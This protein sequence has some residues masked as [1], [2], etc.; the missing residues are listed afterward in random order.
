MDEMSQ[1]ESSP[2]LSNATDAQLSTARSNATVS[3]S[4]SWG[5]RWSDEFL[6]RHWPLLLFML[7]E[8]VIVGGLYIYH[9]MWIRVQKKRAKRSAVLRLTEEFSLDLLRHFLPSAKVE[10][11]RFRGM[12]KKKAVASVSFEDV[13][14]ELPSGEKILEG[15]SGEFKAGRMCAIMG[16]S[17]AGKTSLMNVLCGK[18]SYGKARGLVRFNGVEGDYEDYKTVMGFVPQDDIV[19]EGLTVGEQIRFSVDLRNP[20]SVPDSRRKLIYED[21]LNVM[22]LG[23]IQN[24][25]VGGLEKRGISGGQRKRVSIGLELAAD[26]TMLFLDEPTSGLDAASSLSI[27]HSLKKLAQLG[28]TSVMVVHQPR[29]SLFSL[30]DEVLLLGKGGRTVYLGPAL[31]AKGYFQKLGFVASDDENPADWIMDLIAGEIP[32]TRIPHFVPEMLYDLWEANRHLVQRA[33]FVKAQEQAME[34]DDWTSLVQKLDEDWRLISYMNAPSAMDP[35]RQGVLR[36]ADLLRLL[37]STRQASQE[38]EQDEMEDVRGAIRQ[39]LSRIAGPSALVCNK[40]EV[41]EFLA[42]L[43]GVVAED[44]DVTQMRSEESAVMKPKSSLRSLTSGASSMAGTPRASIL[45]STAGSAKTSPRITFEDANGRRKQPV[46]MEEDGR[47][48]RSARSTVS[49]VHSQRK[50]LRS[51]VV[52]RALP[53]CSYCQ[54]E[55]DQAPQLANY[56]R[57]DAD[58]DSTLDGE[59]TAD[60]DAVCTP[61]RLEEVL[62][63][64]EA[65]QAYHSAARPPASLSARTSKSAS[66]SART[67][68]SSQRTSQENPDSCEQQPSI[69]ARG[70]TPSSGAVHA[71]AGDPDDALPDDIM[72]ERMEED[73]IRPAPPTT[74][75]P[76]PEEE[77]TIAGGVQSVRAE[78][79]TDSANSGSLPAVKSAASFTTSKSTRSQGSQ[80]QRPKEFPVALPPSSAGL[81]VVFGNEE[82]SLLVKSIGEGRVKDY[83]VANPSLQIKKHDH[84]TQVNGLQGSA[85]ALLEQCQKDDTLE[86]LIRSRDHRRPTSS[87]KGTPRSSVASNE[88]SP[89]NTLLGRAGPR[90]KEVR[91][92]IPPLP[93]PVEK[94]DLDITPI[95][96]DKVLFLGTQDADIRHAEQ[97]ARGDS[98]ELPEMLEVVLEVSHVES[99]EASNGQPV[100]ARSKSFASAAG[101]LKRLATEQKPPGFLRQM[102]L[103][104]HRSSIQWWRGSW[105]R[106][107]FLGVIS[108]SS[109]ILAM[110]D[111]FVVR[112]AEWQVLP[113]LNLHTTLA[114]LTAVF[115]L[116]L[117]STD[118]PVFWRERESGLSVAAFYVS[119]VFVNMFDLALQCFLLASVYYMIRQPLVNF[120]VYFPPFLLV[121]FAASGLGYTI[122]TCFPPRHGPFITAIC[123][124]VSCGLLGHPLRVETMAD[125]GTLEF[126]MDI[127]S[128]TRWSVAHYYLNYLE[129]MDMRQ[130]ASD[131]EAVE[132]IQGIKSI[133]EGPELLPP[134]ILGL[135]M[136]VVFL[137]GMALT[138][139]AVGFLRL[140][141][142]NRNRGHRRASPWKQRMHRLRGCLGQLSSQ[143]LGEER[144]A[145]LKEMVASRSLQGEE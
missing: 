93:L 26:P 31:G 33:A 36:E 100:A 15:V 115:C 71:L 122:S 5:E 27:V 144:Q 51:E 106:A 68:T 79:P 72:E 48:S 23:H 84:I 131:P 102:R 62:L 7:L 89:S 74:T 28:M 29:Y 60:R 111:T 134:E 30:F 130:F 118:R 66:Q 22:Q 87:S 138:W 101:H 64:P 6:E 132:M 45:S 137:I 125:G 24:S 57:I 63:P 67:A 41:R 117:F 112:E 133:Y 114:L 142:S 54:C 42:G 94:G 136:E 21:V 77:A 47:S 59:S 44:K 13:S 50:V 65:T 32:N 46:I 25:I 52:H 10:K 135:R 58:R 120:S 39:L 127:L 73:F 105:Q 69:S 56:M 113:Y 91:S 80:A 78:G 82:G 121:S 40:R 140:A 95:V 143:L 119:K 81:G 124:F 11:Y 123:I 17:G 141:Y 103:L 96:P 2:Y 97:D 145:R 98:N 92:H 16:P 70:R 109:V 34:V 12:A 18:A 14:L 35:G 19:H 88:A 37:K 83:N 9:I 139:H 128:I 4:N 90:P 76:E 116:N 53:E 55:N 61:V 85:E 43:Q 20:S 86:L 126:F 49:E 99:G 3:G 129:H 107:I 75:R 1:A 108:G 104:V 38:E 8:L 110:M